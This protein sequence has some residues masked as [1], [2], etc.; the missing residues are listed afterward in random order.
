VK[1]IAREQ[2]QAAVDALRGESGVSR[3]E[4]VHEARKRIKK[5]RALLA[6]G[7]GGPGQAYTEQIAPVRDA[8]RKVS[9]LRDEAALVKAFD[10][11]SAKHGTKPWRRSAAPLRR[12]LLANKKEL[13]VQQAVARDGHNS[14]ARWRGG[15]T[16]AAR[17]R[18]VSGDRRGSEKD[19]P[20]GEDQRYKRSL[21]K[22]EQALG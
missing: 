16:L 17:V 8:G 14:G 9:Q 21:K 7:R 5:V 10:D 1:R 18:Q 12:A 3:E 11:L 2:L 13:G 20:P 19:L 22:L 4:A 15:P 6:I